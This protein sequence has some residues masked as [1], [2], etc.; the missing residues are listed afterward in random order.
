RGKYVD[1]PRPHAALV[2]RSYQGREGEERGFSDRLARTL[3]CCGRIEELLVNRVDLGDVDE[4]R[5]RVK[6]LRVFG[7]PTLQLNRWLGC[8]EQLDATCCLRA[9]VFEGDDDRLIRFFDLE[10][11]SIPN[12]IDVLLQERPEWR[13]AEVP[14]IVGLEIEVLDRDVFPVRDN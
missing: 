3:G 2:D 13:V 1:R 8:Q 14:A 6:A 4:V 7:D 5:A 12:E 10:Y 9:L 11:T